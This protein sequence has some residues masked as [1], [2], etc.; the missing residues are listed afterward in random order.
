MHVITT[1]NSWDMAETK[2]PIPPPPPSGREKGKGSPPVRAFEFEAYGKMKR[3]AAAGLCLL[4]TRK[5]QLW[6]LGKIDFKNCQS[7]KAVRLTKIFGWGIGLLEKL[8]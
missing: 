2:S 3:V 7:S 8:V 4:I 6:R 5:E 1:K